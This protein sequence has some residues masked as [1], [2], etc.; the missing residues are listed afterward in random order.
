MTELENASM[1]SSETESWIDERTSLILASESMFW[2]L[3][4][5]EGP[6]AGNQLSVL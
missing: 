1:K 4:D 5:E 6:N 3:D 2:I